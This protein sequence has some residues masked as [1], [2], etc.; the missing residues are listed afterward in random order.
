MSSKLFF[1]VIRVFFGFEISLIFSFSFLFLFSLSLPTFSYLVIRP[2]E[3][4]PG[5]RVAP[6]VRQQRDLS[7]FAVL[8][9]IR[10]HHR[11]APGFQPREEAVAQ[12]EVGHGE[13][14]VVGLGREVGRVVTQAGELLDEAGPD[15]VSCCSLLEGGGEGDEE[16]RE[17]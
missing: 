12:L 11:L 13:P 3:K 2:Q 15:A 10:R 9:N 4:G 16:G 8:L 5:H 17:R 6:G 14:P 7:L 1:I